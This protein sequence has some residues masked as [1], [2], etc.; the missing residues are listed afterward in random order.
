[1]KG[2]FWL[3]DIILIRTSSLNLNM[4]FRINRKLKFNIFIIRL[5]LLNQRSSIF[6]LNMRT[7]IGDCSSINAS[8]CF[9]FCFNRL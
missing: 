3:A 2:I 5:N 7:K 6:R 8:L 1:M 4:I 9:C